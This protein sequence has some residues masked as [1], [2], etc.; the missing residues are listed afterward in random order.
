[1]NK[2]FSSILPIHDGVIPEYRFHVFWNIKASLESVALGA[3]D[4]DIM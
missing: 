4:D 1:M 2:N 3:F